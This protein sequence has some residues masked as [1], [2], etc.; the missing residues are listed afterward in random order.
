MAKDLS[1]ITVASADGKLVAV[2]GEFVEPVQLQVVCYTLFERLPEGVNT[3][4]LDAYRKYGDPDD[5]LEGFY[6]Q[7]LDA[8]VAE[9]RV[10]EGD[11]R[12]WFER[13]LI[14][15][16]GTRGLVFRDD[17]STGDI[18]NRVISVLEQR[19]IIRPEIR[20]GSHWYELSH[21]RF[22]RPIQRANL[23][24]RSARW[25]F[26]ARYTERIQ[27]VVH[28]TGVSEEDLRKF[29][30][31]LTSADGKRNPRPAG[32]VPQDALVELVTARL[33]RQETV[34]GVEH[35][36]MAG[37]W[38]QAAT[39]RAFES[40]ARRW[41]ALAADRESA[42]L[43]RSELREASEIQSGAR[44]SGI[45]VSGQFT[46]FFAASFSHRL[47]VS[48]KCIAGMGAVFALIGLLSLLPPLEA[49]SRFL[50]LYG[51]GGVGAATATYLAKDKD[52]TLM[53]LVAE[54]L[55]LAVAAGIAC[56]V[57]STTTTSVTFGI[58][59]AFIVGFIGAPCLLLVVAA[60]GGEREGKIAAEK[61]TDTLQWSKV[62]KDELRQI[63]LRRGA[64]PEDASN[65]AGL[66]ISGGGI[67][68]A[69]FALGVLE[70]LKKSGLLA[71][72]DYLSTVSGGGFIGSWLSAN[73]KRA[74]DARETSWLHPAR[75]WEES[76]GHLR[77]Y[78]KYLAP[79][80][81]FFSAD[82]WSMATVWLR[83]ALVVQV[84]IV[85]AMAV[86][87]MVPR[88]LHDLFIAWPESG[89]WRWTTVAL[90]IAAIAG[91]VGNQRRVSIEGEVSFQRARNWAQGLACAAVLFLLAWQIGVRSGFDPFLNDKVDTVVAFAIAL[92]MVLAGYCLLPVGA[93][94]MGREINYTQ[95]WV[96]GMIVMPMMVTGL[97]VAAVLW[98]QASSA[99]APWKDLHGYGEY[100]TTEWRYW[101]FP[102]WIAL[103]SLWVQSFSSIPR[104]KNNW[105]GLFIAF[106][107]PLPAMLVLY[108]LL[109]AIMLL[110]H[111][112]AADDS[113]GRWMAFVWAPSLV[114]YAFSLSVVMLIGIMGRETTESVR[115]WWSR[116]GAW[117]AIYGAAWMV[118]TIA[119][120]Y[121]PLWA[122]Y[123][124]NADWWAILST[125]AGWLGAT[126]T[127]LL[128]GNSGATGSGS[129][130]GEPRRSMFDRIKE[131]A[132]A[133]G[134]FVFIAGMLIGVATALHLDHPVAHP[135]DR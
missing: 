41:A 69:T 116:L 76:I 6:Q 132:A 108:L 115:E 123:L 113:E 36:S 35:Y 100:L 134:P 70:A 38:S 51:I 59:V 31:S 111:S 95:P 10:D 130:T 79:E 48:H 49:H 99:A 53:S 109:C 75:R 94:I 93:R 77:R 9:T 114:L 81:G 13:K 61:R 11:L 84:T 64:R 33:L 96:Q 28:R 105:K 82:T 78:S 67:R 40:R 74:Q 89:H 124:M 104:W 4:T 47:A 37:V 88:P 106:L 19:H 92:L 121:G 66:A 5:A 32:G 90:F 131:V 8:A 126:L 15:P 125:A 44:V 45:P 133:V 54:V 107:A 34:D 98:G 72:I 117:L 30:D 118:I 120:V 22:I 128:A 102:L 103:A 60:E 85:F 58:V 39:M 122:A 17:E 2:P 101:P 97:L 46:E 21:D 50:L 52:F 27:A 42:L 43:T 112:W 29:L 3:V 119:G 14:T 23:G 80:V 24:W 57:A 18:P 25:S 16:A 73:C 91:V 68:S 20:S 86:A 127:G 83:N 63:N 7:A 87:L 65:L 129:G 56:Y 110:L 12:E 26:E 55:L 62:F 1:N 71:E 135:G